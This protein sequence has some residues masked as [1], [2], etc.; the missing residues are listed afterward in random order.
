MSRGPAAAEPARAAARAVSAA[1]LQ[2]RLGAMAEIGATGHGGVNRQALTPEDVKARQLIV[3]WG[4]EAGL[5][6]FTDEIGNIFLRRAG[7]DDGSPPVVAGSHLDSQPT[8][9]RF[10]GTYGVLAALEAVQAL[11]ALRIKTAA[12]LEVAVWTNEEGARF[13]PGCLG[14]KAFAD[15]DRLPALL[16]AKDLDG[17]SVADALVAAR[18][19]VP[20]ATLRPLGIPVKAYV[21]A[22]IEQGPVLESQGK[23]IGVVT[24]IA[25]RRSFRVEIRG[26]EAHAG[27]TPPSRR[28][29]AL[30]SALR[31][32]GGLERLM[33]DPSET[34]R[35]TV[36]RLVVFPNAPSVVPGAVLFTVDFRHPEE[37]VWRRLG[38]QIEA[39]CAA[40]AGPCTVTV[41]EVS[42]TRPI[43]FTGIVRDT[44]EAV[45]QHLRLSSM[46]ILSG[47]GHDAENLALLCP[48]GMI[49][50]PCERGISHNESENA[51]P[52]D[53]TAGTQVL[54]GVLAE[55]A[56]AYD[57]REPASARTA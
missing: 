42:T 8:G 41:T 50:V 56:G 32:I 52:A 30:A 23:T 49:F 39:V 14:S 2:E 57:G 53:L 43:A 55:L 46:P 33:A 26:E 9:G 34:V 20:A 37:S 51:S 13:S 48:T 40:N 12:P 31:M 19:A 21:E 44:I 3:R 7:T 27:T 45:A 4:L 16:A 29:D 11:D 15:A 1:R 24:G 35:F 10:D 38:D 54:A 28:R 17:I 36:G 18:R 22:H 6:P 5:E 25:G 47:A